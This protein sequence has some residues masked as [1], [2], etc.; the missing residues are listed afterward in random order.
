MSNTPGTME[1][2]WPGG[3]VRFLAQTAE[4]A[5]ALRERMAG[6]GWTCLECRELCGRFSSRWRLAFSPKGGPETMD[7]FLTAMSH[8]E[9]GRM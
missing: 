2:T 6:K 4:S 5:D 7:E 3:V 9:A 8:F 1:L